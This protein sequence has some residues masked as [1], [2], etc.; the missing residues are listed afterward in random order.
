[1]HLGD[2]ILSRILDQLNTYKDYQIS[3]AIPLLIEY[4]Q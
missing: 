3:K 4:Y 2:A 1:M